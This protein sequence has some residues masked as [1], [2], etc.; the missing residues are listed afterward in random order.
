MAVTIVI[1]RF[2]V[3]PWSRRHG[4]VSLTRS[5]YYP[6]VAMQEIVERLAAS[7]RAA[8]I[9]RALLLP[10]LN[11]A[12]TMYESGYA[13]HDDIDAAMRFGCGYPI[14]PLTLI[15]TLGP[16]VVAT[17]LEKLYAE[18]GDELH[19]PASILT[20][21]A[22]DNTTFAQAVG[23]DDSTLLSCATTSR[24]SA[25]WAPA[26]WHPASSRS[27]PRPATTWSTSAA[28][29]TSSPVSRRPSPRAST[30]RSRAASST[31][32]ASPPC[33]AGSAARPNAK[34]SPAPTSSS[35]RSPRTST[36]SSSC[37]ATSTASPSPE[38][39]W[40]RRPRRC[41]SRRAR[42]SPRGPRTSS[43]CTSSTPRP[44]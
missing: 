23:E 29:R 13:T 8:D 17:G 42:K 11:H 28:A 25:S 12:A 32:T 43:A 30:R 24:R 31:R 10:Y 39:S 15:D 35:R 5:L 2:I 9:A 40:P 14:G 21:M 16:Q 22:A 20:Q 4:Q 27:S 34:P 1:R 6:G 37:S 26:R 38:R 19:Q 18:T 44:S 33:W 7:D 3:L 36:S 41:R